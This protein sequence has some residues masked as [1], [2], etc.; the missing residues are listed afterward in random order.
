[1]IWV[2]N[3][4]LKIGNKLFGQDGAVYDKKGVLLKE[5]WQDIPVD[6]LHDK[7]KAVLISQGKLVDGSLKPASKP[8]KKGK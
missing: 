1:M 3:G 7:Q 5:T 6:K 4:V 2:G 8:K